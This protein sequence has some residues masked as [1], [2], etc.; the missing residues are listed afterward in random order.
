MIV[1]KDEFS[2]T[3]RWLDGSKLRTDVVNDRQIDIRLT[4]DTRSQ[5]NT[6]SAFISFIKGGQ[7]TPIQSSGGPY[8]LWFTSW[9]GIHLTEKR[10]G[11]YVDIISNS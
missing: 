1:S 2:H 4:G 3:R 8:G 5:T 11:M 9:F 6:P 7:M 10:I